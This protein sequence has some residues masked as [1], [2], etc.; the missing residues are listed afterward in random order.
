MASETELISRSKVKRML[1]KL[2]KFPDAESICPACENVFSDRYEACD[3]VRY[4]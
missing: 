4:S 1:E 3:C 2:D